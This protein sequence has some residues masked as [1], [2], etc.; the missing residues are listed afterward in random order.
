MIYE[1]L[2]S[3]CK[4]DE[5]NNPIERYVKAMLAGSIFGW[6]DE[7]FRLGMQETPDEFMALTALLQQQEKN[8]QNT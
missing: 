6:I 2:R 7:W 4:L 5:A 8:A 3:A 1:N